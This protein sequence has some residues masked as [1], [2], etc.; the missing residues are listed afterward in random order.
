MA[1]ERG[2]TWSWWQRERVEE[3]T[4]LGHAQLVMDHGIGSSEDD[5]PWGQST[6]GLEG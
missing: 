5:T 1:N 3:V 2:G 4:L 6:E